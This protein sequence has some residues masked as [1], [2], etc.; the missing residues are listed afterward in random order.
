ML[1]LTRDPKK[2]EQATQLSTTKAEFARHTL[3]SIWCWLAVS[4]IQ[5]RNIYNDM[6]MDHIVNKIQECLLPPGFHPTSDTPKICILDIFGFEFT[7]DKKLVATHACLK[8]VTAGE[9]Q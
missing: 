8:L 4:V 6:F 5:A 2:P 7:P 1:Y 9:R 3:V